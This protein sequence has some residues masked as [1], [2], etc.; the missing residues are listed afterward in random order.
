MTSFD[1][2]APIFCVKLLEV[3]FRLFK[4][5]TPILT[6]LFFLLFIFKPL[7]LYAESFFPPTQKEN[8]EEGQRLMNAGDLEGA[9]LI[10]NDILLLDPSHTPSYLNL[11]VI[12]VRKGVIDKAI[13]VLEEAITVNPNL[14]PAHLMLGQAYASKK[15]HHKAKT[16]FEKVI[17]IR[18]DFP[19]GHFYLGVIYQDEGQTIKAVE[20]YRIVLSLGGQFIKQ[21]E[22]RLDALK[23]ES[24]A[25]SNKGIVLLKKGFL[26]QA[27]ALFKKALNYD[28]GNPFN[29]Y[30]LGTISI[31]K[32]RL[33]EAIDFL[34]R[35]LSAKK[36]FFSA[37]LLLGEV[38][39][40]Q[41]EIGEAILSY[42]R[43]LS[44]APNEGQKEAVLARQKLSQL[45]K[46]PEVGKIVQNLLEKG[47][48]LLSIQDTE[49]ARV[50]FSLVLAFLP[51]QVFAQYQLGRIA[52][53]ERYFSEAEKRFKAVIEINKSHFLSYLALG[54]V[55]ERQE[56][57]ALA[58]QTYQDAAGIQAIDAEPMIRLGILFE[59]EGETKKA[60]EA[61]HKAVLL[62][63]GKNKSRRALAQRRIDFHE[64]RFRV[65]FS[66]T[67]L[68]YDSNSNQSK[69]AVN[70][71]TSATSLGMTY[72]LKKK[73]RYRIP[74]QLNFNARF[75]HRSQLQFLNTG[76]GLFYV[77]SFS[78]YTL[79]Q[80]YNFRIGSM[81]GNG[82][83]NGKSFRSNAYNSEITLQRKIPSSMTF[84]LEY[85]D[86][87]VYSN[88]IFDAK[89][90]TGSGIF[91]Q[92]LSVGK[93]DM[94][95]LQFTYRYTDNDIEANDQTRRSQTLSLRY[96]R[97]I[98]PKLT[99]SL[100]ISFAESRFLN[101]DSLALTQGKNQKRRNT[102]TSA[103]A[104]LSYQLQPDVS[105]FANY[106]LNKN[107]SNLPVPSALDLVD[108]NSGQ[109][110]SLGSYEQTLVTFGMRASKDLRI[111]Y[112]RW[113]DLEKRLSV[114]LTTAYYRP[115]LEGFNRIIGNPSQVIVQDPNHLLPSNPNF[116]SE[117]RNL[118]M[119]GI[120]G[121]TSFG[122]EVEWRI[123]DR[124]GLVLNLSEWQS[125]SVRTDTVPLLLSPNDP[126][127]MVPRSARYNL[128]I[129]QL[130]LSW[131]HTLIDAPSLG[132]LFF[133]L[134]LIGGSFTNLT[135]DSLMKVEQNPVGN[136]FASLGSIEARGKSF[137]T[138]AG[139]GG[140]LFIRPW[141][142][143]GLNINYLW[144]DVVKLEVK[145]AFPSDFRVIPSGLPGITDTPCSRLIDIQTEGETLNTLRCE[146]DQIS[147]GTRL[148]RLK[149]RLDGYEARLALRF[150]FGE[151]VTGKT[152][153]ENWM[154]RGQQGRVEDNEERSFVKR[155]F[156]FGENSRLSLDG[157]LKFETAYR[158]HKPIT[159][160]KA[161][162][163]L[164]LN[165]GYS[166]TPKIRITGRAR[167]FYDAIYDFVDVDTISPR[168]FENTILTQLPQIPSPE[169][170][171]G[172]DVK[173]SR[174][175]EIDQGDLEMREL[176]IDF[177][178]NRMDL[179][180]GKQIVRWGVV[181][182]SRVT[183][184]LNPMDFGEFILRETEDRFIP[185]MMVKADFF[186]GSSRFEVVWI[187]EVVPHKP[188]PKGSEFEQ[189]EILPGFVVPES[190]LDA[191]LNF[192]ADAFKNTEVA[193]RFIQNFSGWEIGLT[194]FYTWDD[195][196]TSFRMI[197]GAGGGGFQGTPEVTFAPRMKRITTLGTTLSKSFGPLVLNTEYAFVFGKFFGTLLEAGDT[198]TSNSSLGELE[199]D[200]MKYAIGLDFRLLNTDM[201]VQFIQ[202]YI[203]DWDKI[204]LQE[205]IE[206]V[207]AFFLRK[208][209]MNERLVTRMLTL[210]FVNEEDFLLRP[211]LEARLTDS[212]KTRF[213]AD[214]FIG[215]RGEEVGQFDFIGFFKDSSRLF[216][217]VIYSF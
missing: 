23:K 197:E 164:R 125:S 153:F 172:V 45:G 29:L 181:P 109:V 25:L 161:L 171:A 42:Q 110:S 53:Q 52:L 3:P 140:E 214:V 120:K 128:T 59:R 51:Q 72:F 100:G 37:H 74:F 193:G 160:T 142:S 78:N 150:H 206:T 190:F 211:V 200:F 194:A 68:I 167:A 2:A 17:A 104:G 93:T 131:R 165:A 85:Q 1:G 105:I 170:I 24:D 188:A 141:L 189:F 33:K 64:N 36:D 67:A 91:S 106:N 58:I 13:Q 43:V 69:N 136:T 56:K 22:S 149:L 76:L 207:T 113:K 121:S 114:G 6:P 195:F 12:Y 8:F 182:G 26:K 81:S 92:T 62:P 210:Y 48:R 21:V 205:Q 216:F 107:R 75:L 63:E 97:E 116:L 196:P 176:F 10:F 135:I 102:L 184:E 30:N 156:S 84:R 86:V 133:D 212:V 65:N 146:G 124:N 122:V 199:R 7:P 15:I 117:T 46:T 217:E 163:L 168:R 31:Q 16:E 103:T 111:P 57:N 134:G 28:P 185:I 148:R 198:E 191:S 203:P 139:I 201:S 173:N 178:F 154:N 177:Q 54:E 71:F 179:R 138:R 147:Q 66:D 32:G 98:I 157:S 44:G 34:K 166:L 55:Y 38:F 126:A 79:L 60:L 4:K 96:R 19:S 145:R 152:V 49:R 130:F 112:P 183:D 95:T 5:S 89:R 137:T 101:A 70:E 127:L 204:I 118:K 175:V 187:T 129:N 11:G 61:Y 119:E 73:D 77:H 90:L 169:E 94:G 202:Q 144:G 158:V 209:F 99:G 87:T 143:I 155:W 40:K 151:K 108:I 41:G 35:A 50:E 186:P 162:T 14:L 9:I 123:S 39:E 83:D 215:D 132:R 213:G 80:G 115:S 192:K 82:V 47:T 27:A 174:G 20:H 18:P 88:R 159:F 180:V 208:T